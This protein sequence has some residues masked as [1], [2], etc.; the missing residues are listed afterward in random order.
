M[1]G[2]AFKGR[3]KGLPSSSPAAVAAAAAAAKSSLVPSSNSSAA[4]GGL[5]PRGPVD[6]PPLAK[7]R[8]TGGDDDADTDADMF[9]EADA[10]APSFVPVTPDISAMFASLVRSAEGNARSNRDLGIKM[11]TLNASVANLQKDTDSKFNQVHALL[12]TQND[13]IDA[14]TSAASSASPPPPSDA[15]LLDMKAKIDNLETLVQALRVDPPAAVA[16]PRPAPGAATS[17]S[18]AGDFP[19]GSRPSSLRPNVV[20]VKGLSTNLDS[21]ILRSLADQTIAAIPEHFDAKATSDIRGF[22]RQFLLNLRDGETARKVVEHFRDNEL[23]VRHPTSG[24][25]QSLKV[26]RDLSLDLRLKNRL[27]GLL[28]VKVTAHKAGIKLSNN[29]GALWAM[30]SNGEVWDLFS[31]VAD[32]S[33]AAPTVSIKANADNLLHYN[34]DPALYNQWVLDAVGEV[35]ASTSVSRFRPG[36]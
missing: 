14:I 9:E 3:G 15:A 32:C 17:S 31:A 4:T 34:I 23:I 13:R 30:E 24:A 12:R 21:K 25:E 18:A 36:R 26:A 19:V 29:R 7:M 2:K 27:L 35:M 20:W 16:W 11:D 5:S 8:R 10:P 28:W 1:S 33:G 22:G 6:G